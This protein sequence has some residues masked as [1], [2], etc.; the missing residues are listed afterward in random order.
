MPH[1]DGTGSL[2]SRPRVPNSPSMQ[3]MIG[4]RQPSC[5]R[6]KHEGKTKM[7]LRNTFRAVLVAGAIATLP[8]HA[9]DCVLPPPPSKVPDGSSASQQEMV[10][11]MDTLKEYNGDVDVYLKCLDFQAKQNHISSDV[12]DLKHDAAVTQL[13]AIADKFN[14]QVRAFKSKHG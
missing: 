12:R 2:K 6:L 10:S 11:A 13:Q 1:C 7:I 5:R 8:V 4:S 9:D 14:Q 3:R